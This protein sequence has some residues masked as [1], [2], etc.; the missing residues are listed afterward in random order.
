LL[1]QHNSP[2]GS[3]HVMPVSECVA[4]LIHTQHWCSGCSAGPIHYSCQS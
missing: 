2:L 4:C 3:A 1:S